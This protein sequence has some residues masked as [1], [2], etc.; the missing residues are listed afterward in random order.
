M[1]KKDIEKISL[2]A[3]AILRAILMSLVGLLS[4]A[5]FAPCSLTYAQYCNPAVVSYIVR[6]EKG[7]VLTETELKSVH[8]QLP[9][10]IGDAQTHL[11]DI[12]FADDGKSYYW[13]DSVDWPKGEKVPSL[14]FINNGT[15]TMHLSEAVLTYHNKNMRL[16]FNIEITREQHDR[17]PVIDSLPFQEGTFALD[18]NGWSHDANKVIPPERW[19]KV[20]D[21]ARG[22]K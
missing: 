13:R 4:M 12:S 22:R 21:P 11:G 7:K 10:L 2:T 17:R 1:S 16:I 20:K 6:D 15:C 3:G 9:K 14:E 18:L 19:K 5:T 8:E